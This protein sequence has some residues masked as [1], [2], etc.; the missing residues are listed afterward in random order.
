MDVAGL[1]G[2]GDGS[3]LGVGVLPCTKTDG[4]DLRAGVKFAVGVLC[5]HGAYLGQF[6]LR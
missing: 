2:F 1:E 3:L 4:W 6:D 5:S